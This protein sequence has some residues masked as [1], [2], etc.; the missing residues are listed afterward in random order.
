MATTDG[1]A[2]AQLKRTNALTKISA[3]RPLSMA[4]VPI[5]VVIARQ[6]LWKWSGLIA[7]RSEHG[8]WYC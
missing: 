5:P 4:G 6:R 8:L 2:D 3:A 7:T 1:F